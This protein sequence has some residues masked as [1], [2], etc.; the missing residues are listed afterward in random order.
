[1]KTNSK[2]VRERIRTHILECVTGPEGESYDTL[3]Q[4][5]KRLQEEFNRVA[6]YPHN[7][8]RIPNNQDRFSDYLSGLPF[9]FHFSYYDIQ[10]YLNSLGLNPKNKELTGDQSTKL[11]HY[12]IYKEIV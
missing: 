10:Q 9:S 8:K 7:V 1:M 4:A 6:N 3:E 2:Q 5:K 11:Y 12:L